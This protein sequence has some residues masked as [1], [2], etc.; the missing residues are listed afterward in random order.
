MGATVIEGSFASCDWEYTIET[1]RK[2]ST[3]YRINEDGEYEVD[4]DHFYDGTI[5]PV[6]RWAY[7]GEVDD[8]S[9]MGWC[10]NS[11]LM[12]LCDNLDY[13]AGVI[14][15]GR[16]VGYELCRPIIENLN[17]GVKNYRKYFKD[18]KASHV[19]LTEKY[20]SGRG[21]Y[22]DAV[23]EGDYNFVK[24][25]AM[26]GIERHPYRAYIICNRAGDVIRV[27]NRVQRVADT[28]QKT[29]DGKLYIHAVYNYYWAACT[30]T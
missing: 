11:H 12:S 17:G 30:P 6:S 14:V 15:R 19:L 10:L 4:D 25:R 18:S 3:R 28:K 27:R 9:L 29:Q 1:L 26:A 22:V 20:N 8:T 21:A 16:K 23:A 5:Y 13:G 24:W 2:Q 7:Q